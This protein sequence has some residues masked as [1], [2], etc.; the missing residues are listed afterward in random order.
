MQ[1]ENRETEG[2]ISEMAGRG[3]DFP[4][5][6][7]RDDSP[8]LVGIILPGLVAGSIGAS[9]ALLLGWNWLGVLIAY[10]AGGSVGLLGAGLF[11]AARERRKIHPTFASH[12]RVDDGHDYVAPRHGT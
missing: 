7:D 10:S 4:V 3:R 2:R 9:I 8:S 11:I 1:Q 12:G 6:A 5:A